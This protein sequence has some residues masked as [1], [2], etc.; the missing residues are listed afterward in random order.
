MQKRS[1]FTLVE[2]LVVIAIM[3]LLVSFLLP[4][5][6][7][8][9]EHAKHVVCLANMKAL[10]IGWIGYADENDDYI[11]SGGTHGISDWV[12]IPA[13]IPNP[14]TDEFRAQTIMDGQLWPY[15]QSLE[16]YRCSGD[17][18]P[19]LRSYSIPNSLNGYASWAK[20]GT[21]DT[22]SPLVKKLSNIHQPDSKFVFLGEADWRSFNLG[23]W[24]VYTQQD[25]FIDPVTGWHI[26]ATS[27]AFADGRAEAYRW[28]DDRT[29]QIIEDQVFYQWS[30]GNI[31]LHWLQKGYYAA[32]R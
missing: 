3:A 24:V 6:G 18:S 26:G 2:L 7:K 14:I 19:H 32:K 9:K 13:S 28:L 5:L 8:A 4:A 1:G 20:G 17:T 10:A 15:V 11:V 21:W 27:F 16:S 30:T 22:G 31:D 23:T 12:Y 29:L 25:Q